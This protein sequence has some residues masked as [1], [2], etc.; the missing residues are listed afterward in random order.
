MRIAITGGSGRIGRALTVAALAEGHS[1]VSIDRAVHVES[2]PN[3]RFVQ[4]NMTAYAEL[5]AALQGCDAL[6]HLAAIPS[7]HGHSDHEVHNN[8]VMGSYNALSAAV[9]LGIRRICQA[10]SINAIGAAYS[11]TP[12]FDYFPIDERHPSYNEDAY[13]LSKWLCEQQADMFAR[14][15]E[16]ITIASLRFHWIVPN[17][18]TAID[19]AAAIG[20]LH[21]K[22]LWGYTSMDAAVRACLHALTAEFVGHEPFFVVAPH[23]ASS[24]PSLELRKQF[25]PD[26]PIKRDLS[27]HQGFFDCRKAEQLLGWRHDPNEGEVQ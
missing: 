16:D 14:R 4:A 12:R 3:V 19:K 1:V 23:T 2:H 26:V 24:T 18:Q 5:A 15:Y 13:S 7:P 6:A 27:N 25:Y 8:N 17:R 9:H 22:H 21:A 11:R 20:D 10:S